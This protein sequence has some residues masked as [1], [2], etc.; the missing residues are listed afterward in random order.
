[1][2]SQIIGWTWDI[3]SVFSEP[4]LNKLLFS[5]PDIHALVVF[6]VDKDMFD[7]R[8]RFGPANSKIYN[9]VEP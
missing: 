5:L 7:G 8:Y 2:Y 3:V 9:G 6:L 4:D 1:M